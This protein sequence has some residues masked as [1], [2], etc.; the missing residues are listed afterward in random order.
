MIRFWKAIPVCYRLVQ[1][2]P[3]EYFRQEIAFYFK[4][5]LAGRY[6]LRQGLFYLLL[7]FIGTDRPAQGPNAIFNQRV[8]NPPYLEFD[9]PF[10]TYLTA[11]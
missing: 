9:M 10:R 3:L 8:T 5:P 2:F 4:L 6:F 11:E 1:P 7:F